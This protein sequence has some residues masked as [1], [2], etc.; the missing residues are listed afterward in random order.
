M[1]CEYFINTKHAKLQVSATRFTVKIRVE[2]SRSN[3]GER[4][5]S[6]FLMKSKAAMF[7]FAAAEGLGEK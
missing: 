3:F 5:L 4:V 2:Q 7:D 1:V 6:I